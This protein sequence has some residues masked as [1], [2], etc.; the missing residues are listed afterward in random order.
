MAFLSS[1]LWHIVKCRAELDLSIGNWLDQLNCCLL[2]VMQF[3]FHGDFKVLCSIHIH[4]ILSGSDLKSKVV[5]LDHG[6]S[7]ILLQCGFLRLL[8][9]CLKLWR[10]HVIHAVDRG[11]NLDAQLESLILKGQK[12]FFK[13]AAQTKITLQTSGLMMHCYGFL[14]NHNSVVKSTDCDTIRYWNFKN[15]HFPLRFERCWADY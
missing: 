9:L 2:I 8:H 3:W 5:A 1:L 7:V 15:V 10:E 4:R 13:R 14:Y 12:M 11:V 6:L